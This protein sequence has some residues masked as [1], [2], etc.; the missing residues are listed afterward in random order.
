MRLMYVCIKLGSAGPYKL[1]ENQIITHS[2]E[3]AQRKEETYLS[4]EC[5]N[6]GQRAEVTH[7]LS[8]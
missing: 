1:H 5:Q 8:I 3:S 2:Q 6:E 7:P 4:R